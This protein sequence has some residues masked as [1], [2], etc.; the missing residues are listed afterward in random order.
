M[1]PKYPIT[2]WEAAWEYLDVLSDKPTSD[3]DFGVKISLNV[4]SSFSGSDQSMFLWSADRN[5]IVEMLRY[6]W[7]YIWDTPSGTYPVELQPKLNAALAGHEKRTNASLME[8]FNKH[9]V[10]SVMEWFC[11]YGE[12]RDSDAEWAKEQRHW[13]SLITGLK[14]DDEGWEDAF[15][16]YLNNMYF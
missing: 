13:A 11:T 9:S 14:R 6:A 8:T 10:V 3:D 4:P 12:L 7:L 2:S 16:D 5:Q 1:K 15:K